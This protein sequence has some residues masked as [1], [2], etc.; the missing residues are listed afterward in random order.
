MT[1]LVL[2]NFGTVGHFDAILF[3]FHAITLEQGGLRIALV[4]LVS[5]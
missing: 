1:A 5:L 2:N 4:L 3:K